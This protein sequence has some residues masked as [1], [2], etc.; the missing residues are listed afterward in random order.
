MRE[1]NSKQVLRTQRRTRRPLAV[2]RYA[3][4][5][6]S[7]SKIRTWPASCTCA[8]RGSTARRDRGNRETNGTAA[9]TQMQAHYT[10]CS[11]RC[12]CSG[13]RFLDDVGHGCPR[14]GNNCGACPSRTPL[15]LYRRA[16]RRCGYRGCFLSNA[17]S[18][19]ADFF[20]RERLRGR[21]RRDP[22]SLARFPPLGLWS[23][24]E[25]R[26]SAALAR[27]GCLGASRRPRPFR[28]RRLLLQAGGS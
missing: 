14:A 15:R 26:G 19:W 28:S 21:R 4:L 27:A 11:I 9:S 7:F 6:I 2:K 5:N 17:T 20:P 3:I 1:Q 12:P 25:V 8:A 16:R 24:S 18:A 22:D 10:P 13:T 23:W